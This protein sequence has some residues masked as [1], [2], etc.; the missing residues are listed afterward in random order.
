MTEI[1]WTYNKDG[2]LVDVYLFKS[3]ILDIPQTDQEAFDQAYYEALAQHEA[4]QTNP[5]S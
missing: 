3:E 5:A 1:D 4:D 2:D